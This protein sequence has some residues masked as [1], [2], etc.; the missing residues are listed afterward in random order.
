MEPSKQHFLATFPRPPFEQIPGYMS[1]YPM[2]EEQQSPNSDTYSDR[3]KHRK[4]LHKEV[5]KRRRKT[6]N[7]GIEE[8]SKL[9]PESTPKSKGSIISSAVNYI[10]SL[11]SIIGDSDQI[12][13]VEEWNY[14]KVKFQEEIKNLNIQIKA[15]K[16]ENA[17]LKALQRFDMPPVISTESSGFKESVSDE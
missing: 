13:D 5:E 7:D 11:K 9:L 8:L 1:Y 10:K 17:S 2:V 15:L 6:I 14:E 3:I 16:T 4:E 12:R